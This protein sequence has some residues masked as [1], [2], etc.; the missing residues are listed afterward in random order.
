MNPQCRKDFFLRRPEERNIAA[1]RMVAWRNLYFRRRKHVRR[2]SRASWRVFQAPVYKSVIQHAIKCSARWKGGGRSGGAGG[3]GKRGARAA[4]VNRNYEA[5][6]FRICRAGSKRSLR[7]RASARDRGGGGGGGRPGPPSRVQ[8]A[9]FLIKVA[10]VP[11]VAL[12]LLGTSQLL[13]LHISQN[14]LYSVLH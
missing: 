6:R 4:V 3:D 12:I 14:L 9:S 10:D 1:A 5:A 11:Q 2:V 13:R 7:E 8:C